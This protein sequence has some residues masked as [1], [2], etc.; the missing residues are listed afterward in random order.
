MT[1]PV[2]IPLHAVVDVSERPALEAAAAMLSK[3]LTAVV[4][5][6]IVVDC[7]FLPTIADIQA[8]GPVSI[9]I[10]SLL[11]E[12]KNLEEA[13]PEAEKRLRAAYH[14]TAQ[15]SDLRLFVITIFRHVASEE[16]G[17]NSAASC[18]HCTA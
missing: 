10:T 15:Q 14:S 18:P 7:A 2:R 12:L 3:E 11:P 4:G 5:S 16:W 6:Q 13:W 1:A 8:A 9:A 17:E